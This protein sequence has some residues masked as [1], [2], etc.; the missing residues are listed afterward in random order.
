MGSGVLSSGSGVLGLGS[1]V[2]A[3]VSWVLALGSGVVLVF[4]G[5]G[6]WVLWVWGLGFSGSGFCVWG[7]G[8]DV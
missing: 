7:L 1:G 2:L 8:A 6:F 4:R 3:L 5:L